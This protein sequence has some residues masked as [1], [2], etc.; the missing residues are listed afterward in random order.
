MKYMKDGHTVLDN[1]LKQYGEKPFKLL[2]NSGMVTVFPPEYANMIRNERQLVFAKAFAHDF[3]AKMPGLEP[4]NFLDLPD[5]VIQTVSKKQLTK[6]LNI[7]TQP[8]SNESTFAID[9]IFGNNTE[10]KEIIITDSILQLI[11]R[12]SGKVFL[13]D[14]LCRNESWLEVS[15][16]YT[17]LAVGFSKTSSFLPGPLKRVWSWFVDDSKLIRKYFK[18]ARDILAPI[19]ENRKQ[20][21]AEAERKGKSAPVYNDML[22]WLEQEGQTDVSNLVACQMLLSVAAIHTTSELLN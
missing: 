21:K 17:V 1:A 6:S 5:R 11:A 10:W 18:E 7:M 20:A 2:T 13:G 22:E 4:F 9:K 14:E 12:L 15:K 8:L 16:N 3:A 19:L